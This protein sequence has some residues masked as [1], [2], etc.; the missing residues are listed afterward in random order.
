MSTIGATGTMMSTRPAGDQTSAALRRVALLAVLAIGAHAAPSATASDCS[1]G[2]GPGSTT[3]A[4]NTRLLQPSLA[5]A[6]AACVAE[7]GNSFE[8]DNVGC[9]QAALP[10]I[11]T[12]G[13]EGAFGSQAALLI[14]GPEFGSRLARGPPSA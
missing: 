3:A 10:T 4:S 9:E 1:V 8:D 11:R 7:T 12:I 2:A 6:I 5:E 13:F 14:A